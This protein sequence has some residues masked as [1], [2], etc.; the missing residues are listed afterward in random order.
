MQLSFC[1]RT[2]HGQSVCESIIGKLKQ[3]CYLILSFEY[4]IWQK[5]PLLLSNRSVLHN[6]YHICSVC[7]SLDAASCMFHIAYVLW[8][9]VVC[10]HELIVCRT[11]GAGGNWAFMPYSPWQLTAQTWKSWSYPKSILRYCLSKS[12]CLIS[13][14]SNIVFFGATC[15]LKAFWHLELLWMITSPATY[16]ATCMH[17]NTYDDGL[18]SHVKHLIA[19]ISLK[20]CDVTGFCSGLCLPLLHQGRNALG[21]V[22]VCCHEDATGGAYKWCSEFQVNGIVAH[23]HM[24]D[25]TLQVCLIAS[26]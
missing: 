6:R 23:E 16:V 13:M 24:V 7:C 9:P 10:S 14:G 17:R 1:L 15:S 11:D 12:V 18:Y 25:K 26:L 2:L 3:P 4:C 21:S 5:K 20:H 8:H 22:K 19:I